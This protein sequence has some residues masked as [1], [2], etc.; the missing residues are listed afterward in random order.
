MD[1]TTDHY[2]KTIGCTQKSGF[3][4]AEPAVLQDIRVFTEEAYVLVVQN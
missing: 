4:F 1:K 3:L 2:L